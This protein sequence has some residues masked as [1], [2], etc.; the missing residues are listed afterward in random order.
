MPATVRPLTGGMPTWNLPLAAPGLTIDLAQPID[1]SLPVRFD[2][3]AGRAFG[4]PAARAHAVLDA[5][6]ASCNCAS[7]TIT[8]HGDGTHTEGVGHLLTDVVPVNELLHAP[9]LPALLVSVEP[10]RL[11]DVQD[12]ITGNHAPDDRVVDEDGL[13]IAIDAARAHLPAGFHPTALV[14][15]AA[16]SAP[17]R[18]SGTNPPYFTID[19]MELVLAQGV[20]HVLTDL[21]SLDR[22]DDGGLLGAHRT[23]FSLAPRQ[24]QIDGPP[25]RRTVTELCAIPAHVSPGPYALSLQL[26]PLVADAVP[27]RPLLF[28]LV[29]ADASWLR[30]T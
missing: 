13:R 21:P 19:A 25:P 15:R 30:S 22:E 24:K 6:H 3:E 17:L 9:L 28:P 29:V 27:S 5:Q 23:F 7:Y 2:A 12:E 20:S 8:P 14:I 26:A 10:R 18:F 1:L 11:D 4:L 16:W